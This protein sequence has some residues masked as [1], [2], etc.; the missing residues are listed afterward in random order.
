MSLYAVLFRRMSAA[1]LCTKSALD[2]QQQN[3]SKNAS[4]SVSKYEHERIV[5]CVFYSDPAFIP[6]GVVK[7]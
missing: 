1:A 2:V 7:G 4:M 5:A 6:K 3:M